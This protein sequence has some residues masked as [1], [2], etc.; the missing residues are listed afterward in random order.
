MLNLLLAGCRRIVACI[1]RNAHPGKSSRSTLTP[2]M[3][4]FY[5]FLAD[6]PSE[7]YVGN[8]IVRM[9]SRGVS[10][11]AVSLEINITISYR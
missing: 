10:I 9:L 6:E 3:V 2:E 7:I 4:S 8:A 5:F 11:D 1:G